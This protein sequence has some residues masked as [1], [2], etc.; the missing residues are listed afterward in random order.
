[1]GC[2]EILSVE[3]QVI[4][5]PRPA[6]VDTV[7]VLLTVT[8]P[9]PA[10][11]VWGAPPLTAVILCIPPA[12]RGGAVVLSTD[13]DSLA[14]VVMVTVPLPK[15]TRVIRSAAVVPAPAGP[16]QGVQHCSSHHHLCRY[17]LD[18]V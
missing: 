14:V 12:P 13:H 4:A 18:T 2:G 11:V 8:L 15:S 3:T 17:C 10:G 6:R 9:L 1:M 7:T 16:G 5:T